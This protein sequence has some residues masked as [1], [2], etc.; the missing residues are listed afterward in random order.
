VLVRSHHFPILHADGQYLQVPGCSSYNG[1]LF[2]PLLIRDLQL[3][4][5]TGS[6]FGP[7]G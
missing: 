2:S 3:L 6:E 7:K 4:D 1:A 5:S